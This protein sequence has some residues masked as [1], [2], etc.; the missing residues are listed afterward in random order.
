MLSRGVWF[1]VTV[2]VRYQETDGMGV[3]YHGNYLTWFEIG[4]TEWTRANG[5][6]YQEIEARGVYL[7]VVD[8]TAQYKHPARYDDE[9]EVMCRATEVGAVRLSFEY[10]L[11]LKRQPDIILVT[12]TSK[13]VW[14]DREW[15][16]TRLSKTA[17]DVYEALLKATETHTKP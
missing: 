1:T 3:V 6:S 4:R 9:V 8:I 10:Q 14:V 12:G 13:H 11:R 17:P 5:F 15:K 7:P 2:R 16:P